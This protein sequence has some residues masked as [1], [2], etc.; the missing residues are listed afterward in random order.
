MVRA[1]QLRRRQTD[2]EKRL[3]YHLRDRRLGDHELR[4][5]H[6]VGPFIVD[7]YCEAARLVIEVY[8]GGT[9]SLS[10]ELTTGEEP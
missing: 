7:F 1:R 8:G 2:A 6:P 5:Q 10:K 9:T 4:R 3:R